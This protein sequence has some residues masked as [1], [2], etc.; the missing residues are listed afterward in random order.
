MKIGKK[1]IDGFDDFVIAE[2][3][4]EG[5]ED[6]TSVNNW[7]KV[8]GFLF[9][10]YKFIR[11]RLQEM[12]FNSLTTEEKK[13]VCQ[14]KG[15]DEATNKTILGNDFEYWMTDFDLKSQKCRNERF[16]MAKTILIK[17]ISL[18]NRYE[19][20]GFLNTTQLENNYIKF[21]IEGTSEGDPLEGI[22]NFVEGTGAYVATGVLPRMLTMINGIT[23]EA[24]IE[25]IMQCLRNGNY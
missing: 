14:F 6:I 24:M 13:I 9:K 22:F 4:P 10:D 23:K 16:S 11:K 8:G 20:L 21:G 12:D 7:L 17:N 15:S 3:L 2:T 5:Y 18:A 19:I 25:Q 1:N